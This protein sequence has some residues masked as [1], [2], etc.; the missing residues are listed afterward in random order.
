LPAISKL[1]EDRVLFQRERASGISSAS[2]YFLSQFLVEIPILVAIVLL[3]GCISYWLVGLAATWFQFLFFLL[4]ITLVIVV[5]FSAAQIAS[6][7]VKSHSQSIAIYMVILVYSLL[8]GGFMVTKNGVC[9]C[10][11]GR[12]PVGP[13]SGCFPLANVVSARAD[14]PAGI[15]WILYTSY[16]YFGYEALVTK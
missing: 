7:L 3:Y 10:C 4:T 9:E 2:A 16:F 6:A 8:L 12:S 5:G 1:I 13:A 14:L 15:E 11:W